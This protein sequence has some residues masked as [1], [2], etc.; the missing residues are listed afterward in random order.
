MIDILQN[1]KSVINTIEEWVPILLI[2]SSKNYF[3]ITQTISSPVFLNLVH[4][5]MCGLQLHNSQAGMWMWDKASL[6]TEVH[7]ICI[8][9]C[10]YMYMCICFT[11]LSSFSFWMIKIKSSCVVAVIF[12]FKGYNWPPNLV[13]HFVKA[14]KMR[15]NKR[16]AREKKLNIVGKKAGEFNISFPC[17][18]IVNSVELGYFNSIKAIL[19]IT[20]GW[21]VLSAIIL[22]LDQ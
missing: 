22:F 14:G 18:E 10:I 19:F 5:K 8:S 4:F 13:S 3:R 7:W 16:Q 6:F 1:I 2:S 12:F 17:S 9:I 20:C 15:Q 11:K 21:H